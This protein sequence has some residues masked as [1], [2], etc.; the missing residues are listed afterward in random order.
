MKLFMFEGTPE[1]ISQ[2]VRQVQ[3]PEAAVIATGKVT[4]ERASVVTPLISAGR[5]TKFVTTEFARLVLS[6]RVLSAPMKAVLSEIY[7]AHPNWVSSTRLYEV[8]GYTVAQFAGLM[9]A[10]GRRMAH[11]KG[12]D[13]SAYFFDCEWDDLANSWKYRLPE[14]VREALEAE[15]L[16]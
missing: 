1:E 5:P 11:T 14:M 16:V 4:K 12:F 13:V 8:S 10:F 3:S 6:R 7:H 15:G 2:V 9:G